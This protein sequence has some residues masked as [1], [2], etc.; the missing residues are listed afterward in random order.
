L[1]DRV[2]AL[3]GHMRIT[4]PS[5]DGTVLRVTIPTVG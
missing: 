1:I 3:G 4:S 5:G 2:E